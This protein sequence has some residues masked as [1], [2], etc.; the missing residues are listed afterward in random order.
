MEIE[1]YLRASFLCHLFFVTN[2]SSAPNLYSGINITTN[3][4][5]QHGPITAVQHSTTP[6]ALLSEQIKS[7]LLRL[8]LC[9]RDILRY[10]CKDIT[11]MRNL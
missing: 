9:A 5:N 3:D 1:L 8:R 7:F 2:I 4:S 6:L 11:T 10:L